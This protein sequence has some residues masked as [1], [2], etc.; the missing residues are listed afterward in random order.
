MARC[1]HCHRSARPGGRHCI[2]CEELEYEARRAAAEAE[3]GDDG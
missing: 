3:D 1:Q 2:R